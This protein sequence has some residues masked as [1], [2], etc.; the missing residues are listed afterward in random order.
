MYPCHYTGGNQEWSFENGLIRHHRLCV[1]LSSEDQM[2][3][4]LA[5]CDPADEGQIWRRQGLH[6][7]HAKL[8]E[9]LDTD[10][11]TLYLNQCDEEKASQLFSL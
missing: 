1:S 2:T 8:D 11:P 3:A 5:A 7:R 9:C 4:V 6:I 10:R